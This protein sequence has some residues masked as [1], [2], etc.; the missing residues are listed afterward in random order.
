MRLNEVLNTV[1]DWRWDSSVPSPQMR[2]AIAKFEIGE[3]QYL[4]SFTTTHKASD[5]GEEYIASEIVFAY[6]ESSRA[7]WRT[8]ITRSGNALAV[9]GTVKAVMDQYIA[10]AKPEAIYFSADKFEPSR[11]KLYSRFA[12]SL[13]KQGSRQG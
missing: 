10:K 7:K 4:V 1:I 6:R 8:D 2:S 11:T 12:R 5:E 9:F 3:S 13:E